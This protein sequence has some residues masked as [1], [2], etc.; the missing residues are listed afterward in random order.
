MQHQIQA[1]E[2]LKILDLPAFAVAEGTVVLANG[3]ALQRQIE[4]GMQVAP[5]LLTGSE[6]YPS[7]T[8]GRLHLRLCISDTVWDASVTKINDMDIFLLERT[9]NDAELRIL[10][11]AALQLR[12]PLTEMLSLADQ[13]F[14]EDCQNKEALAKLNRALLS[15]Q[16][17]ISNMADAPRYSNSTNCLMVTQNVTAYFREIME[18]CEYLLTQSGYNLRYSLPDEDILA[19]VSTERLERAIYNLVSNAVKFAPAGSTIWAKLE[20]CGELLMIT[21]TDESKGLPADLSGNIF[22]RYLREP[23]IEDSRMGMGLGML[24]VCAAASAHGGTVLVRQPEGCGLSVTMTIS[25]KVIQRGT[26]RSDILHVDYTGGQDHALLEL[27]DVLSPELYD[28]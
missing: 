27:S 23:A 19:L 14:I 4:I 22:T 17:L 21:V 12:N 16:R 20:K 18:K 7:F 26:V 10:S 3:A 15:L 8:D 11:L 25:T 6:S 5:L 9:A 13:L 2:L 28:R 1:E 24:Y